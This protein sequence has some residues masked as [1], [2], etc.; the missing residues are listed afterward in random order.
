MIG[1]EYFPNQLQIIHNGNPTLLDLNNIVIF[2]YGFCLI[3]HPIL[4]MIDGLYEFV[5]VV[6]WF[7]E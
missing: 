1:I 6:A 3:N 4:L 7:E 5:L 2:K